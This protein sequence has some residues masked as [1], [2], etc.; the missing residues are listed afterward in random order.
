MENEHLQIS[1][2]HIREQKRQAVSKIELAVKQFEEETGL[3]IDAIKFWDEVH[4]KSG[5]SDLRKIFL[6]VYV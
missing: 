2:R 5:Q 4:T 3:R 6:H 1:I